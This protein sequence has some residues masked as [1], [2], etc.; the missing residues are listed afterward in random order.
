MKRIIIIGILFTLLISLP[1]CRQPAIEINPD[2]GYSL[3]DEPAYMQTFRE[4]ALAEINYARTTPSLY[5]QNRL[6]NNYTNGTDNGAYTDLQSRSP[7][8]ALTI[9]TK[10]NLAA[11]KYAKYLAVNNT[12]G[13]FANGTPA[14]RCEAEGFYGYRAENLAYSSYPDANGENDPE[15]AAIAFTRQLIIDDG[16]ASL[17]HRENILRPD[18]MNVV[19]IGYYR[20][21]DA[22]YVNYFV[23]DFGYE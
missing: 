9:N 10:L 2:D 19:G 11:T 1:T 21:T 5:A 17:G 22:Y 8:N 20:D 15:Q 3:A 6:Q 14:E 12:T 7:V 16:V 23:Q 4:K 13:H 18:V